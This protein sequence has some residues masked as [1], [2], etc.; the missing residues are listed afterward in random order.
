MRSVI[1]SNTT[2][3]VS[4]FFKVLRD[5]KPA[6]FAC[7]SLRHFDSNC[8]SINKQ[9]SAAILEIVPLLILNWNSSEPNDLLL[10]R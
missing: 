3:N 9:T 5:F 6:F 2:G 10:A 4:S 8:S 1:G 7:G